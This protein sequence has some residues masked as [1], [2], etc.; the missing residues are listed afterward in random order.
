MYASVQDLIERFG[1]AE[2]V[3]LTDPQGAAIDAARCQLKLDD[4]QALIDGWIGAVWR[5]PLAGCTKP[6]PV[7]GNPQATEQV[8][9]PQLTRIACDLARFWLRDAV[10]ED[11]DVYRRYQGAMAEL[12]ALSEQRARL[13]CP[14]GGAPGELL[15]GGAL[16][17]QAVAWSF[18]PRAITDESLRG[19]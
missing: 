6:A 7:P 8:P 2:L 19:F 3:Q 14:W 15:A 18:A 10:A 16:Q 4:A 1:A 9:P 5:L 11:S 12:K 13:I 17:D